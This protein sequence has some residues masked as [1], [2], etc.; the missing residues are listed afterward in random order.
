MLDAHE[1]DGNVEQRRDFSPGEDHNIPCHGL[2]AVC[3]EQRRDFS[4]G[5]DHNNGNGVDHTADIT[6]SAGTSAPARI[7]TLR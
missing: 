3:G 4:P 6:G 5:E 1:T 7:T 2:I